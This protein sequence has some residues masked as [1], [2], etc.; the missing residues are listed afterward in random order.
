MTAEVYMSH[1]HSCLETRVDPHYDDA[2]ALTVVGV[3]LGVYIKIMCV[4][5]RR[6]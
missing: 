3:V 5:I 4:S 2:H 1:S 6:L